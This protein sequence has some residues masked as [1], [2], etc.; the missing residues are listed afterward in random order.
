ME[1]L[2]F[3]CP[4]TGRDIDVGIDSELETLLRIRTKHVL[5]R[6]PICGDRHEWEVG[7]ARLQQAA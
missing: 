1:H 5:A 3:V 4:Q 7:E 6:C 2:H